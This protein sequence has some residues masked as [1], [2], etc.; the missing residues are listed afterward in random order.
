MNGYTFW[1][2]YQSLQLHFYTAN[3]NVTVY[4]TKSKA[5]NEEVF[6]KRRDKGIFEKIAKHFF[7]EQKAGQFCIAN[8]MENKNWIYEDF[9]IAEEVYEK[10]A[11][12]RKFQND[13]F[14]MDID[15]ISNVIK[16]KKLESFAHALN[17]TKSGNFPPLL[18][19]AMNENIKK[20]TLIILDTFMNFLDNWYIIYKTDPFVND[21]LFKLKKYS[22]FV[23]FDKNLCVK[24]LKEHLK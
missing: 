8:F 19:M 11:N 2:I 20:E 16:N 15:F 12:V 3:F 17:K 13:I 10:W 24:S 21:Y 23:T 9:S 5:I 6:N 7:S 22:C 1:K 4:G 18:Q 14:N